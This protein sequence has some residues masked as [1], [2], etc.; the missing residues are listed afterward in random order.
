MG[1]VGQVSQ[2][3][4]SGEQIVTEAKLRAISIGH[5]I[6]ARG[7]VVSLSGDA[8]IQSEDLEGDAMKKSF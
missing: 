3:D 4:K 7:V 8:M 1:I 2:R 5:K 6:K